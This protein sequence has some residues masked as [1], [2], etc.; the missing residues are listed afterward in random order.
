MHEK[1]EEEE[2]A[3]ESSGGGDDDEEGSE[4]MEEDD[5][6][7][8]GW[9]QWTGDGGGEGAL[10]G[11]EEEEESD[12]DGDEGFVDLEGGFGSSRQPRQPRRVVMQPSSASFRDAQVRAAFDGETGHGSG[13]TQEF[14]S[15]V[16]RCVVLAQRWL[17]W[18]VVE[19]VCVCWCAMLVALARASWRVVK[20]VGRIGAV[21]YSHSLLFVC[22]CC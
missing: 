21:W 7:G 22:G 3:S 17:G 13:P 18:R 1:E 5:G 2:G 11:S 6:E 9:V 15:L 12:E 8:S 14:Y 4:G 19:K 16:C 10:V 20:R